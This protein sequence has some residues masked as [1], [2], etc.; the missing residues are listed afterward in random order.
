[1]NSPTSLQVIFIIIKTGKEK[2]KIIFDII[3]DK[4]LLSNFKWSHHSGSDEFLCWLPQTLHSVLRRVLTFNI[5]NIDKIYIF[6]A[7]IHVRIIRCNQF[8]LCDPL[9][10]HYCKFLIARISRDSYNRYIPVSLISTTG[11]NVLLYL[12][13]ILFIWLSFSS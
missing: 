11:S 10:N 4:F 12:N 8:F 9:L 1:M 5:S 3:V 6:T 2:I 13:M 7:K